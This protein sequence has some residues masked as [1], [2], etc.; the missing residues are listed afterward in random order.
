MTFFILK[1][2]ISSL[3]EHLGHYRKRTKKIVQ[4]VKDHKYFFIGPNIMTRWHRPTASAQYLIDLF[5]HHDDGRTP[6]YLTRLQARRGRHQKNLRP[7]K[8]TNKQDAKQ[9]TK[10][11]AARGK[12]KKK[13]ATRILVALCRLLR[14]RSVPL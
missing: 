14:Q 8:V 9:A 13:R 1:L 11:S 2:R 10:S 3:F 7:R 6:A 12:Y 4:L 5:R